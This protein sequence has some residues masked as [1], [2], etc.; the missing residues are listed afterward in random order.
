VRIAQQ[1]WADAEKLARDG[2]AIREKGWPNHPNNLGTWCILGHVL[3]A[4]EKWAEAEGCYQKALRLCEEYKPPEHPYIADILE[5]YADMLQKLG[6]AAEAFEL[7]H[8][9]AHIREFHAK[10]PVD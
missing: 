7:N 1:R 6:R 5:D 10:N 2:L 8:R 3:K 9:A 4:Q